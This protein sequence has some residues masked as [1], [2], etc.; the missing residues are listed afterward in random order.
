MRISKA[1][2]IAA[3]F[4][5]AACEQPGVSGTTPTRTTVTTGGQR[6]TIAAPAGFCVD[7][8]STSVT[9]TGAFV[10]V[11]DC[12]L[13]ARGPG[14]GPRLTGAAASAGSPPAPAPVAEAARAKPPVGA[15]MT[16]SVSPTGL[17]D[18]GPATRS[19][20]DLA[21]YARTPQGLALVG[22]GG[23]PQGVR[24]LESAER[25]GV[26]Y[27]YVED[28]GPQPIAGLEPR[29]WRAFFEVNGRLTAVSELG[30]AGAGLDKQSG[31]NLV[32]AFT[33]AIKAAN[34]ARPAAPPAAG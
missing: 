17:G 5:L 21:R 20:A 7:S 13:L 27:L 1:A 29:F 24:L 4:L 33:R 31:L 10:L 16:A 30:F 9:S 28:R 6:L 32:T 23:Q 2:G 15:A 26:L 11:T 14:A 18:D 8:D 25:D 12:A 34:P 22:R 19:L 3:L